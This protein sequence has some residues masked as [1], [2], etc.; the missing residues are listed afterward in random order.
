[1]ESSV[2]VTLTVVH[3]ARSETVVFQGAGGFFSAVASVCRGGLISVQYF[4][5]VFLNDSFHI[6]HA[7]MTNFNGVPVENFVVLVTGGEMSGD[8]SEE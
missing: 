6:V 3:Y 5:V 4:M 7:L 2:V 8:K 1:M